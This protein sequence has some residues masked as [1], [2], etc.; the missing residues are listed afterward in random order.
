MGDSKLNRWKEVWN[1]REGSIVVG[2]D[3]FDTYVQLKKADGFDV[4]LQEGYYEG[5]YSQW[6]D[7]NKWLEEV[8]GRTP[9]SIYEV[10]CGSGTNLFLFQ[11][12]CKVK[13][14]GGIDYSEALINIAKNVLTCD[15]LCCDEAI[16]METK[17]EYEVLLSDSAFQYFAD[18]DY[19]V[20]VLK[21]MMKKAQ[22]AVIITEIHDLAKKEEHLEYRRSKVENYDKVY[23]GLDKTY[24]DRKL[25]IKSAE[26]G[27]W[28]YEI[29]TPN[30]TA[31]WN[32]K[33][34]F[35]MYLWR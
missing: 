22:K 1:K 24:Y 28:K 10:G 30:N 8:L 18:Q 26:K 2:N 32:N 4:Q 3:V 15:D 23:E 20:E 11:K 14:I 31:Y 12:Q 29:R 33:F 19:G 5:L 6:E 34:V 13:K 9:E 17:P 7:L 35:D 21:K 16:N 27:G 25:L